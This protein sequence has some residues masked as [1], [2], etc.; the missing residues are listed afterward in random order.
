M[1]IRKDRPGIAVSMNPT[2]FANTRPVS[3]THLPNPSF[4]GHGDTPR[5]E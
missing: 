1:G 5:N 3:E 2:T 4:I